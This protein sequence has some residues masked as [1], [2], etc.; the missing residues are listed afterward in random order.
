MPTNNFTRPKTIHPANRKG[1]FLSESLK[2]DA[3]EVWRGLKTKGGFMDVK[4]INAPP[5]IAQAK[6]G[7]FLRTIPDNNIIFIKQ[8]ESCAFGQG[9][10]ILTISI[11]YTE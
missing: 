3:P 5:G 2:S 6:A 8:S 1:R 7:E 11:F 9:E 10:P 4:I